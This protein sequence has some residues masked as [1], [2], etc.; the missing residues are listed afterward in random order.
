MEALAGV[1]GTAQLL[2][3]GTW[4][5]KYVL[6]MPHYGVNLA[7]WRSKQGDAC[8]ERTVLQLFQ[9]ILFAVHAMHRAGVVHLDLKP[10]NVFL[11]GLSRTA[12]SSGDAAPRVVVGDMGS[13]LMLAQCATCREAR[14]TEAYMAPEMLL[15]GECSEAADVWSLG[16]LLYFLLNN[17]PLSKGGMDSVWLEIEGGGGSR[18]LL[19]VLLKGMLQ[20]EWS[21]RFT[22]PKC[23]H[24]VQA[25]LDEI[26]Q[27]AC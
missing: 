18:P 21:R 23:S 22:L 15:T 27:A 4:R 7:R 1:P 26:Q 14:G 11:S 16:C 6:L 5:G 12:S 20:K 24:I 3:C 2:D 9:Q 25:L 17:R 13:A 10:H 19:M 8:S